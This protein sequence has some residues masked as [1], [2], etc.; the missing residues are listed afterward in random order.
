MF[1]FVIFQF[2]ASF[3][4]HL[5]SITFNRNCNELATLLAKLTILCSILLCGKLCDEIYDT[6]LFKN[7]F[8]LGNN[9]LVRPY[10]RLFQ[11]MC[12]Q[13][14]AF[15]ML[16]NIKMLKLKT[17]RLF[18]ALLRFA[19]SKNRRRK[20]KADLILQFYNFS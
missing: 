6:S 20:I 19:S 18:A 7:C 12:N 10:S 13:K 4:S 17:N 9:E 8:F 2:P 15:Y 16:T 14:Y 3:Y 11:K 1:L 5:L